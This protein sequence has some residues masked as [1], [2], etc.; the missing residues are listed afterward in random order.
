MVSY[1]LLTYLLNL[2][3][4]LQ[5]KLQNKSSHLSYKFLNLDIS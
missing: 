4:N 1:S 5:K 2:H 3:Y